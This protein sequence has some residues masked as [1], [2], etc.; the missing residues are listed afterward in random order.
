MNRGRSRKSDEVGPF[1]ELLA[2]NGHQF[3]SAIRVRGVREDVLF[4]IVVDSVFVAADNADRVAADAQTRP[5]NE[6]LVDGVADGCVG[7]A[8]PFRA[9]VT[10]GG[11]AGE[12]IV[13]RSE[14]SSD[15]AL[16][17]RFLDGLQV[18]RTG[19]QEQVHMRVN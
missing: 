15:S 10:L 4:R 3:G 13:A 1:L 19:M 5:G 8:S 9:H 12:Q 14:C 11:E 18:F 17:N 2:D 16:R 7:G 6:P